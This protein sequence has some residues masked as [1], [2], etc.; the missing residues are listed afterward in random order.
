MSQQLQTRSDRSRPARTS[1]TLSPLVAALEAKPGKAWN[2]EECEVCREWLLL[3]KRATL[4]LFVSRLIR[5]IPAQDC[6]D[7]LD[8]FLHESLPSVIQGYQPDRNGFWPYLQACLRNHCWGYIRSLNRKRKVKLIPQAESTFL[9]APD[10]SL[11]GDPERRLMSIEFEELAMRLISRLKPEYQDVLRR[12]MDG[13]PYEQI[14]DELGVSEEMVKI[15][16][17][18]ARQ[19][20]RKEL[21]TLWPG[22]GF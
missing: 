7:A 11:D 18:R 12:R 1:R 6:A 4:S 3:E 19:K 5:D 10:T 20:L 2:T 13:A 17:Y 16:L 14:A 21:K 22:C 9:D 8:S 15:R